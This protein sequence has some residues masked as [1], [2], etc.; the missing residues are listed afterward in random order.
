MYADISAGDSHLKLVRKVMAL[1]HLPLI[2]VSSNAGF[3]D[4]LKAVKSG[5]TVFLPK[6]FDVEE[7]VERL[8]AL[9]EIKYERPYRV[10]IAEDDG[11]L[12]AFYQLTLEHAAWRRAWSAGRRN[13]SIPCPASIPT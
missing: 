5:A 12:A 9:E 2:L 8:G 13:C 11:P 3:A 7:L 6:P 4:R 1:S 10:V